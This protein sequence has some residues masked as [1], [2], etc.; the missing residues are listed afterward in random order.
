MANGG[1]GPGPLK[2]DRKGQR[3][4]LLLSAAFI[5]MAGMHLYFNNVV[6]PAQESDALAHDKP[7]GNNSDLYPRWLGAR[8]L[9]LH[10]RDPYGPEVS[11]DIQKGYW[12]R[13]LDP[14][15][16]NNPVDENRFAYP[17]YV[18]FLLAPTIGLPFR[19]VQISYTWFAAACTVA[20]V[21]LWL[22]AFG[23]GRSL[24]TRIIA[25]MLLLGSYPVVQALH[26]QQPALLVA[27][28]LAAA[29]AASASGMYWA[30]G[31]ALGLTMIKPQSAGP[32]AGWLLLWSVS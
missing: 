12:G 28:L 8:E 15:K 19:F 13:A 14:R 30:A 31:I 2:S 10:N 25:S 16:P 24:M 7:R 18:V 20:S 9:L 6:I 26:L 1:K 5:L 29:V 32:M 23:H 27:A 22:Y 11:A 4:W 17:L 3:G 21:W